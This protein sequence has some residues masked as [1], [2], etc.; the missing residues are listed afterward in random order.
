MKVLPFEHWGNDLFVTTYCDCVDK[1]YNHNLFKTKIDLSG[2]NDDYFF[3]EVNAE[4]RTHKCE[5]G[6]EYRYR[7]TR[8]GVEWQV[9]NIK[10]Q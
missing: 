9:I 5:C 3:D 2:Y 7:W 10:I 1:R 4:P 6:K 8:E